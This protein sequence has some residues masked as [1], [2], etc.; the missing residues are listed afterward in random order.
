MGENVKG[1]RKIPVVYF[2]QLLGIA[3]GIDKE[4][5]DFTDNTVDPVPV[6]AERSLL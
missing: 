6:L 5:L 3:L 1:F 4:H 2:T